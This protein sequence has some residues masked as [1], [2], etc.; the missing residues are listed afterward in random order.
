M[1]KHK[2][3]PTGKSK[4]KRNTFSLTETL[5]MVKNERGDASWPFPVNKN[6]ASPPESDALALVC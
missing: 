1:R 6:F 5:T 2:N 3:P 4:R